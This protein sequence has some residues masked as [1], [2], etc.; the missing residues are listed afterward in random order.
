[1]LRFISY[2]LCTSKLH[3][4][5]H[6]NYLRTS[7]VIG[8]LMIIRDTSV[9]WTCL[10]LDWHDALYVAKHHASFFSSSY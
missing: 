6:R 1:M 4:F 5:S 3:P 10:G 8:N 2:M 7:L 9:E